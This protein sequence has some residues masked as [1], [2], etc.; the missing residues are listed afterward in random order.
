MQSQLD[1]NFG[2][3]KQAIKFWKY[4]TSQHLMKLQNGRKQPLRG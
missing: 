1:F 2:N 3:I 4:Q